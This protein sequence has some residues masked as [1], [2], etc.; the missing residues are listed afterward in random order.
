MAD[1]IRDSMEQA[2]QS[3][4]NN[5]RGKSS[6]EIIRALND[7]VTLSLPENASELEREA[8]ISRQREKD[9]LIAQNL[10][11]LTR[12]NSET[13][14]RAVQVYRENPNISQFNLDLVVNPTTVRSPYDPAIVSN[15]QNPSQR[16]SP[17]PRPTGSSASSIGV[18]NP[19]GGALGNG[20]ASLF[21]EVIDALRNIGSGISRTIGNVFNPN[22]ESPASPAS[23]DS[24]TVT[25]AEPRPRAPTPFGSPGRVFGLEDVARVSGV[26]SSGFAQDVFRSILS[27]FRGSEQ[28]T[29]NT[30]DRPAR[31]TNVSRPTAVLPHRDPAPAMAE[32]IAAPP[33]ASPASPA[34]TV[35]TGTAIVT[36]VKPSPDAPI[37]VPLDLEGP[38]IVTPVTLTDDFAVVSNPTGANTPSSPAPPVANPAHL[39]RQG[40]SRQNP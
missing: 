7:S 14:S 38:S 40:L 28:Q 10:S 4:H 16:S 37:G 20:I 11:Q 5:L 24:P 33:P 36:P 25:R 27:I 32:D 15:G 2:M 29:Q 22:S 31:N 21:R 18:A 34:S 35:A 1:V 13:A 8:N 39:R 6:L 30:Q 19:I 3:L 17:S 12:M 26:R 23:T 9:V